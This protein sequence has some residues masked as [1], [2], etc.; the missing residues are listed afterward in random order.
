MKAKVIKKFRDKYTGD[1][2]AVD[3]VITVTKKRYNEILET[4]KLVEEVKEEKV[5]EEVTE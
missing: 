4:G 3:D 5:T 2:Y 1:M